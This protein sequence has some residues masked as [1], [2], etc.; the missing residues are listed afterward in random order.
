[1]DHVADKICVFEFHYGQVR[2]PI[3]ITGA[4]K[5]FRGLRVVKAQTNVGLGVQERP[6]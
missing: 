2:K 1:M 4:I 3:T 6:A 5:N